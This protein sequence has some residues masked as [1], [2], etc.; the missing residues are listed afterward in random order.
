GGLE[1][2]AAALRETVALIAENRT[3]RDAMA[4]ASAK[5]GSVDAAAGIAGAILAA[6]DTDSGG[7]TGHSGAGGKT[8][9][10]Y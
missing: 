7:E 8:D 9:A 10:A 3:L 6:L 2:K 4:A 1:Q 5:I